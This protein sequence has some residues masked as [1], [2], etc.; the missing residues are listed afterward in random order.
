MKTNSSTELTRT[1]SCIL[2]CIYTKE[3][4]RGA[5]MG[6]SATELTLQVQ[7]AEIC[8]KMLITRPSSQAIMCHL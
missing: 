7:G 1:F 6:A 4:Q 2:P 5:A 8:E 3:N